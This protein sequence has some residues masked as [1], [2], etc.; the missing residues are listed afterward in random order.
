MV[1]LP[2]KPEPVVIDLAQFALVVVDMQNA[3]LSKAMS[4]NSNR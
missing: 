3:F 2:E 1:P 4:A